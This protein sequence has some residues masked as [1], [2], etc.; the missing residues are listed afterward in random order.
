[1]KNT[2]K[3][4]LAS[5]A[6]I[7]CIVHAAPSFSQTTVRETVVQSP[8]GTSDKKTVTEITPGATSVTTT[9]TTDTK[10]PDGTVTLHKTVEDTTTTDTR[11]VNLMDYATAGV[12]S[13]DEV[14]RMLFKIFDADGNGVIDSNEYERH[15][16]IHFSPIQKDT[17]VTY[18]TRHNGTTTETT[19]TTYDNF[20]NDTRLNAFVNDGKGISAHDFTGKAFNLV[21]INRDHAIDL[22]EWQGTYNDFIDSK[23]KENAD[24]NT[25]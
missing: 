11:T 22:K 6:I 15:Y 18:K 13:P 5:T 4:L 14:G 19:T 17:V 9:R 12:L 7:A 8:D 20:M 10:S 1:M 3:A 24:I 21:D 23:N 25:K 16:I 2:T